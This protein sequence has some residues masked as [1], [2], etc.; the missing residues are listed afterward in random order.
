MQDRC[1][2]REEDSRVWLVGT[3]G[4]KEEEDVIGVVVGPFSFV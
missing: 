2:A 1:V 3:G 4:Q